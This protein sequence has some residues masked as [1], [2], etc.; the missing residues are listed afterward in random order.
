MKRRWARHAALAALAAG[1]LLASAGCQLTRQNYLAVSAG[2]PAQGVEKLLGAPRYRLDEEWVYTGDDPRDLTKASIYF[3]AD[4]RVIGKCWRNPEKPWE[5][6]R[7][8]EV[9]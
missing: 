6:H 2:M 3:D 5:N 7:E 8:G 4:R 1:L 9:P